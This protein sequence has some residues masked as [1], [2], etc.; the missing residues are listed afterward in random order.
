MN[1]ILAVFAL[2]AAL[3]L[4]AEAQELSSRQMRQYVRY[5]IARVENQMDESRETIARLQTL[6]DA[7]DYQIDSA[8]PPPPDTLPLDTLPPPPSGG[9]GAIV[10]A[11]EWS[12]AL[13]ESENAIFDAGARY[14]A[15]WGFGNP[16]F[17]VE[18][19]PSSAW[20]TAHVLTMYPSSGGDIALPCGSYLSA[21]VRPPG[22]CT[23]ANG[24]TD[25]DFG[26]GDV[27]AVR[28]F[29]QV[30]DVSYADIAGDLSFHGI[31][32]IDPQGGPMMIGTDP[33]GQTSWTMPMFTSYDQYGDVGGGMKWGAGLEIP[34]STVA[35]VQIRYERTALE[36]LRITVRITDAVTGQFVPG[37][38]GLRNAYR[39]GPYAIGELSM[40]DV[41]HPHPAN[42]MTEVLGWRFGINGLVHPDVGTRS[43]P[44]IHL[45]GFTY[46]ADDWC[47]PYTPGEGR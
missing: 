21:I 19:A 18:G 43:A 23:G 4:P 45:G 5:A 31:E 20:P 44:I 32:P 40:N 41:E 10:A 33:A 46:C 28:F 25:D 36:R 7:L 8:G 15:Q 1:R 13:G 30:P 17:V 42:R 12:T 14:P 11:L 22:P 16:N 26:I 9:G 6:L 34:E 2:L 39:T 24:W 27:V 37:G 47:P 38:D 29:M 35:L 3:A